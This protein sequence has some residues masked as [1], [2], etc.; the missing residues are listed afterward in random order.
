M[1]DRTLSFVNGVG[2]VA[3]LLASTALGALAP[4]LDDEPERGSEPSLPRVTT[5]ARELVDA[6]GERAPTV[7]PQRIASASILADR[8][9]LELCEPRRVVASSAQARAALDAHR[10]SSGATITSLD[11]TEE[12][13]SL[14]PDLLLINGL[15]DARRAVQLRDA[16]LPVFDLGPIV[17]VESVIAAASSVGALCGRR[18]AADRLV[19]RFLRS[20]RDLARDV[21]NAA[22]KRGLYVATYGDQ[23][24]GGT[25]GSSFGEVLTYAGLVDVAPAELRG[26]P[27]Y[28]T[29]QLLSVDPEVVLTQ[30]GMGQRLCSRP[31][32]SELRACTSGSGLVELDAA[33][34]EDPGLGILD[35]AER[36]FEAVYSR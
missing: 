8:L 26:W 5:E 31:G 30:R 7:S 17:G 22:R 3:C 25:R 19:A 20:L 34:L 4:V 12:L 2:L 16:G 13:L 32:L 28:T 33:L 6:S 15:G 1:L 11:R 9:L 27:R 18:D 21:P 14:A 29:E 24:F 35:A 36:L 23:L 10:F